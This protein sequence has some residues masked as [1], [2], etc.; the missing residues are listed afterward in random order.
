MDMENCQIVF[1]IKVFPVV[2]P[3]GSKACCWCW[4]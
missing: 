4:C 1:Q 3:D 2:Y